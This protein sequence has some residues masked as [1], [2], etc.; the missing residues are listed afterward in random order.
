MVRCCQLSVRLDQEK[1]RF[2]AALISWNVLQE[3]E[4]ILMDRTCAK[5]VLT[6]KWNTLLNAIY[7]RYA[8]VLA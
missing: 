4:S 2:F 7:E 5:K 1:P 8:K 3:A 6:D